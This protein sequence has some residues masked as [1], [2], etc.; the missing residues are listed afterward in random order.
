M[1]HDN[2]DDLNIWTPQGPKILPW[3][4]R[5]FEQI[6]EMTDRELKLRATHLHDEKQKRIKTVQ[7]FFA[8]SLSFCL[9]LCKFFG[10]FIDGVVESHSFKDLVR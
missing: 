3:P 7:N 4:K 2:P 5:Y 10:C 6:Q 8:L 9:R 1:I